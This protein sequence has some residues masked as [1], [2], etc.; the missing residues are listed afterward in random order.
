MSR[1]ILSAYH[2]LCRSVRLPHR[3]TLDMMSCP[4]SIEE[5]RLPPFNCIDH[6]GDADEYVGF[7]VLLRFLVN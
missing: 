5:R 2:Y 3:V 1:R 7:L 6:D 4:L